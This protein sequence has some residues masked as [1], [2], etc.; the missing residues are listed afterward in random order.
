MSDDDQKVK[1]L[2]ASGTLN[3][4]PERIRSQ[5]FRAGGFFD[6][7]DLLQVRYEMVRSAGDEPLAEV[8]AEFGVSVPTCV[9]IR[10]SFREGGLQALAP[11]RRGPRRA[12][13]VSDEILDFIAAYRS[14]H[15]PVG[16]RRLAPVIEERFGVSLHPRTINKA[17][18]RSKKNT[19]PRYGRAR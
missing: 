3:R 2:E 17:I 12:H 6:P 5:R 16:T 9:R 15:G 7:R 13:K 11:L 8:A 10:R 4:R 1:N 18:E 14:E 19:A